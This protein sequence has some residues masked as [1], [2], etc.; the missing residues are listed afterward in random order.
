MDINEFISELLLEE[1]SVSSLITR[2]KV[3]THSLEDASIKEWIS[4]ELYG[5][6]S[7]EPLPEYR[8][9]HGMAMG[10]FIINGNAQYTNTS[11]PLSGTILTKEQIKDLETLKLF[12]GVKKLESLLESHKKKGGEL[13]K[14]IPSDITH[15][16][17]ENPYSLQITHMKVVFNIADLELTLDRLR[18]KC[19]DIVLSI[20]DFLV[21]ENIELS[22]FIVS[23]PENS[24]EIITAIN[25]ILIDES[26]YIGSNNNI[27]ESTF[28]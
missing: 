6:N 24:N 21:S 1:P 13:Q 14:P 22:N 27:E 15:R 18:Q 28:K 20:K 9:L 7:N 12:D 11:I 2:L 5:Y 17:S 23:K 10:N 19:I 26:I 4:K 3:M 16:L 25:N 8:V